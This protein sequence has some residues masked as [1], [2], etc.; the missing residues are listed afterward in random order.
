VLEDESARKEVDLSS[1]TDFTARLVR[2]LIG[3][4]L[5]EVAELEEQVVTLKAQ[6]AE[7][8]E[9]DDDGEAEEE[10]SNY[11]QRLQ[12]E[13]KSLKAQLKPLVAERKTLK[14]SAKV[15]GSIKAAVAAGT[16][17]TALDE[18]LGALETQIA[19]LESERDSV[20]HTMAPYKADK[21]SLT[22]ARKDLK[23]RS[24]G[25]SEELAEAL[26]SLSSS[27]SQAV[28]QRLLHDE[29]RDQVNERLARR[30]TPVL[31]ELER[32]WDRYRL[33]LREYDE[34]EAQ[35]SARLGGFLEEL[36]YAA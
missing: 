30:G 16:D 23:E 9:R 3:D 31:S 20:E 25:L 15:P 5:D 14:G 26:L 11:A 34:A 22:E 28:V 36:G 27:E 4:R 33:G 8:E 35:A 12:A 19:A 18:R 21:S 17:T 1:D 13:L 10:G 7:F 24:A 29:L 32:L 2:A 6:I